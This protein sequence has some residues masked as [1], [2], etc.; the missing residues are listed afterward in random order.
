M[1]VPFPSNITTL[2]TLQADKTKTQTSSSPNPPGPS[3]I[4]SSPTRSLCPSRPGSRA[5]AWRRDILLPG[6]RRHWLRETVARWRM[7]CPMARL[8]RGCSGW[9]RWMMW[10]RVW[11]RRRGLVNHSIAHTEV[12]RERYVTAQRENERWEYV[13]SAV[14]VVFAIT[15]YIYPLSM[16]GGLAPPKPTKQ[17]YVSPPMPLQ[18]NARGAES[19]PDQTLP[20]SQ[21]RGISRTPQ[22]KTK[23][24]NTP[25]PVWCTD[26]QAREPKIRSTGTPCSREEIEIKD[27]T[28][29]VAPLYAAVFD[30]PS[31]PKPAR[32]GAGR[33]TSQAPAREMQEGNAVL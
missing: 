15:E 32:E 26:R 1:C 13:M 20:P 30:E 7:T 16:P 5:H 8:S 6:W 29:T 24:K 27:Q 10:W 4:P 9:R 31:F 33:K 18:K 19:K 14:E 17:V 12:E 3:P 21:T 28:V 2:S 25:A 22:A 23:K 11:R